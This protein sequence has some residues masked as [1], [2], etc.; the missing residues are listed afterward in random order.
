MSKLS[1]IH[2]ISCIE[3]RLYKSS[4]FLQDNINKV[5]QRVKSRHA[6][7]YI[8]LQNLLRYYK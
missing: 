3:Y 6:Y 7:Q 1:V 4:E 8:K 5:N 2:N